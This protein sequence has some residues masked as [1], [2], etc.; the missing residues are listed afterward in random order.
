[1]T[2]RRSSYSSHRRRVSKKTRKA[3]LPHQ[4]RVFQ[5]FF[6][7]YIQMKTYHFATRIYNRHYNIDGFLKQYSE[8]YDRFVEACMGKHG[9]PVFRPFQLS[10]GAI[11]DRSVFRHVEEFRAFLRNI[12]SAEYKHDSDLL[13]ILDEIDAEVDKLLYLLRLE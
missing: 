10:I 6:Q 5:R 7:F 3:V 11:D 9:T 13:N 8:L 4:T 2:T 1:M 12:R